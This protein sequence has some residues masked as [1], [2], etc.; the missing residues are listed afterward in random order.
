VNWV[1]LLLFILIGLLVLALLTVDNYWASGYSLD[2]LPHKIDN[3]KVCFYDTPKPFKWHSYKSMHM[4]NDVL[5]FHIYYRHIPVPFGAESYDSSCNIHIRFVEQVWWDDEAQ[6]YRGLANCSSYG[7]S[8]Q[9]ST[10]DRIDEAKVRTIVHE[11]GHALS[12]GHIRPD[13]PQEA[14][15]LICS[16][17]VMWEFSC[18]GMPKINKLLLD[19]IDCID[20]YNPAACQYRGVSVEQIIN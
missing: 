13:T 9:I 15:S 18:E 14:L 3:P 1:A 19:A 16:D 11:I 20:K 6:D 7:C 2:I 8:I 4:W 12:L 5:P 10:L 17:N